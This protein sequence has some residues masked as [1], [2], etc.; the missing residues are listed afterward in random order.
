MHYSIFIVAILPQ[1]VGFVN[2]AKKLCPKI[3]TKIPKIL[4]KPFFRKRYF[5]QASH[6]QTIIKCAVKCGKAGIKKNFGKYI[7]QKGFRQICRT[8]NKKRKALIKSLPQHKQPRLK[9]RMFIIF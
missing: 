4:K 2:S 1:S 5:L 6:F 8:K 9:Y 7:G 3:G